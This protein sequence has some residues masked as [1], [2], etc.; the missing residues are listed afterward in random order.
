MEAGVRTIPRRRRSRGVE[1]RTDSSRLHHSSIPTANTRSTRNSSSIP[2]SSFTLQRP[3]CQTESSLLRC[4][5]RNTLSTPSSNSSNSNSTNNSLPPLNT[6][7]EVHLLLLPASALPHPSANKSPW[8]THRACSAHPHSNPFSSNSDL[9][10]KRHHQAST[11]LSTGSKPPS[12]HCTSVSPNSSA[13]ASPRPLPSHSPPP[14]QTRPSPS[15]AK[16]SSACS[17]FCTSAVL[18]LK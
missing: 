7:S 17:S 1:G 12:Q 9:H 15:S 5:P 2:A 4:T 8:P 18:P 11:P 6:P 10:R 16:L 3:P 14:T 13:L